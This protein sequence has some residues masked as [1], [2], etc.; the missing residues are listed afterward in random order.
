MLPSPG[1]ITEQAIRVKELIFRTGGKYKGLSEDHLFDMEYHSFQ[2]A[3]VKSSSQK[4]KKRGLHLSQV[5]REQLALE[6]L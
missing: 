4:S 6:F 1:D 3:K 5:Q 2:T